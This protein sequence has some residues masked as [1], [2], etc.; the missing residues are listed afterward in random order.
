MALCSVPLKHNPN[1]IAFITQESFIAAARQPDG[2]QA[3]QTRTGHTLQLAAVLQAPMLA[4]T[5]AQTCN[6]AFDLIAA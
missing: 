1:D 4:L 6:A 2:Q 5:D 3:N